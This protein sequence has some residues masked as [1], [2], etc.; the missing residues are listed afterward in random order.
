MSQ[1]LILQLEL[2]EA[3]YSRLVAGASKAGIPAEALART[4]IQRLVGR[5]QKDAQR[6]LDDLSRIRATLPEADAVE[7]VR[8]GREALDTRGTE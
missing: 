5:T 6:A 2:S 7:V 1:R 8:A 4:A 3:D